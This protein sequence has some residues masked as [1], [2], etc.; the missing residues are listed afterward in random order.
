MWKERTMCG[1]KS[2]CLSMLC[3]VVCCCASRPLDLLWLD[4]ELCVDSDDNMIWHLPLQ[5]NISGRGG[6][7][8][9]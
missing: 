1:S 6:Q 3:F 7:G 8:R 5:H 4:A 9:L 2:E